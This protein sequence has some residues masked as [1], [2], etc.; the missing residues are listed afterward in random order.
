MNYRACTSL[1]IL[2]QIRRKN[3][4]TLLAMAIVHF[5]RVHYS[6]DII[7]FNQPQLVSRNSRHLLRWD[8]ST[9][10]G[11]ALIT[12]TGCSPIIV[13]S[14]ANNAAN[15][16]DTQLEAKSCRSAWTFG[17]LYFLERL[18]A[19][20]HAQSRTSF[21]LVRETR[22]P[23]KTPLCLYSV[24]SPTRFSIIALRLEDNCTQWIY[25]FS[26]LNVYSILVR[27]IRVLGGETR[28]Y[29]SRALDPRSL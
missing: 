1:K 21:H 9:S 18:F 14:K 10:T 5:C 2:R 17:I 28:W 3:T 26:I 15:N 20:N 6:S 8:S 19:R 29:P 27:W 16:L 13:E 11:T 25:A 4:A 22:R 12:L 24:E 23:W 7:H